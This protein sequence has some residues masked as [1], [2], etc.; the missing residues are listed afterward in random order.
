MEEAFPLAG[1][2][3]TSPAKCIVQKDIHQGR[4]E[5]QVVCLFVYLLCFTSDLLIHLI[6]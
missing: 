3:L 4:S 2:N 5:T 1:T 6:N